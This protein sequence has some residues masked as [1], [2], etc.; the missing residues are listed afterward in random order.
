MKLIKTTIC[1]ISFMSLSVLAMGKGPSVLLERIV[2]QLNASGI[3]EF[4]SIRIEKH[5]PDV[6]VDIDI[7]TSEISDGA[8]I[9]KVA[10][11]IFTEG[12]VAEMFEDQLWLGSCQDQDARNSI[13]VTDA[14]NIAALIR[15]MADAKKIFIEGDGDISQQ[16]EFHDKSL[17]KY[18]GKSSRVIFINEISGKEETLL[19]FA[20]ET[21]FKK[22][23]AAIS[24]TATR[25]AYRGRLYLADPEFDFVSMGPEK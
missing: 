7:S 18:R 16:Y 10:Q 17:R 12:E 8:C 2:R 20:L 14:T 9:T 15:L 19:H 6:V 24:N 5:F 11:L 1:L 25:N 4:Q 22:V 23:F 21:D 13:K 3:E